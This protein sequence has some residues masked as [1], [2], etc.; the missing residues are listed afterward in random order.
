M[1]MTDMSRST[2]PSLTGLRFFAAFTVLLFHIWR[3]YDP[4]AILAPVAGFGYI[5]VTFFFILS[6]FILTWTRRDGDTPGKFYW[7]RFSRV[8][9][10][11]F[12][13]TIF[14]VILGLVLGANMFWPSLPFV[15]TLTQAWIPSARF[16]FNVPSW[17]LADEAFFY[18][19][20][21]FVIGFFARRP[22]PL[23][24]MA[25]AF[26][27][28]TVVGLV[29]GAVLMQ[30]AP[31]RLGYVLYTMPL[32]RLGEFVIGILLAVAMQKGWRPRFNLVQAIGAAVVMYAVMSAVV[33][34]TPG[35]PDGLP[36]FVADLWMAPAFMAIVVA[37][38]L[39]DIQGK[40]GGVR[41][42]PVVKLG[43]WSFALYLVHDLVL[44][45]TEPLADGLVG[46]PAGVVAGAAILAC[47]ALAAV[48]YEYFER[49]VEA[50]L[51]A[52]HRKRTGEAVAPAR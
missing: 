22:K 18:L 3:T 21:P 24:W 5:G 8:W 50:K 39:G 34:P 38:A 28:M 7:R 4:A 26:V 25:A 45:A 36:N 49:P 47:I 30:V 27:G 23:R 12:L 15:L 6:G 20:F 31:S 2:L 44:R 11:H 48:L 14:A 1:A 17:S 35:G 16:A 43:Q 32:F 52:M 42:A 51:R 40:T 29:V 33:T 13:T 37:G 19:L 46:F 9:P 10:L 41:S